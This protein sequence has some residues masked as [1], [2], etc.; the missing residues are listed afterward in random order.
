MTSQLTC[1]SRS[2]TIVKFSLWAAFVSPSNFARPTE[3]LPERWL[4]RNPAS[5][6]EFDKDNRKVFHP[7]GLG[8]RNCIGQ[9]LAW[10]ELRLILARVIWNFNINLPIGSSG[11]DLAT[12][13]TFRVWEK[14]TIDV[15]LTPA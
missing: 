1:A 3:F 5:P 15:I 11:L 8:P 12:L 4:P 6:S 7:F 9:N 14:K 2:Q 13:K 10:M